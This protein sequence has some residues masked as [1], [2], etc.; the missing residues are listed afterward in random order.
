MEYFESFVGISNALMN[1]L[2][3]TFFCIHMWECTYT[4]EIELVDERECAVTF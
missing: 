4:L 1:T 3:C 2:E